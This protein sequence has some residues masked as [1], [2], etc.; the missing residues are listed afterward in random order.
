[1]ITPVLCTIYPEINAGLEKG[2]TVY[3]AHV[4]NRSHFVLITGYDANNSTFFYVNDPF[5]NVSTYMY[6]TVSD[7]LVYHVTPK[8]SAKNVRGHVKQLSAALAANR[9][10]VSNMDTAVRSGK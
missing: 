1:V 10:G 3:I 7:L 6:D 5:Y 4:R 2:D 8:R 9:F